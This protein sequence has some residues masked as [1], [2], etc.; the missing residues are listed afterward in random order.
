LDDAFLSG[1]PTVRIVHGKG[2]GTLKNAVHTMLKKH[3]HVKEY[4]LGR[5]GEGETGV[6]VVTLV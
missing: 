6:T 1:L 5:F 3:P 4:R 2:T